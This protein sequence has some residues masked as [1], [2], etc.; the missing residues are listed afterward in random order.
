MTLVFVFKL[1]SAQVGSRGKREREGANQ[2]FRFHR[3]HVKWI[4]QGWP[5]KTQPH[6]QSRP[7]EMRIF[8]R[9]ERCRISAIVRHKRKLF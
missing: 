5:S 1:F 6:V 7:I 4:R 2:W 9:N 3:L 8:H